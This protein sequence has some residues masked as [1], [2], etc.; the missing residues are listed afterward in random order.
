[1]KNFLKNLFRP[2]ENTQETVPTIASKDSRITVVDCVDESDGKK[3]NRFYFSV[4]PAEMMFKHGLIPE[5]IVGEIKEKPLKG[6][7]IDRTKFFANTVFKNFLHSVIAT[8]ATHPEVI[9]E[10]QRIGKGMVTVIDKRVPD[11]NGAIAPDDI[12]GGFIVENGMV[13]GYS[14]NPNHVLLNQF[15]FF[16]LDAMIQAKLN[17]A[18]NQILEKR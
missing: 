3:K 16:K 9:A 17:E 6:A 15:G 10:A 2:A 1:M 14:Q 4:L 8:C 7:P 12:L 18:L 5:A 11:L 13:A